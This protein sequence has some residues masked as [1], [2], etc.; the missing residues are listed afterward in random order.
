M[1]LSRTM[2]CLV[3]CV[4]ICILMMTAAQTNSLTA[5][6]DSE[7]NRS[8]PQTQ[9]AAE[10]CSSGKIVTVILHGL[11][12]GRMRKKDKF[13]VGIVKRAPY[14]K[15]NLTVYTPGD[16]THPASCTPIDREL[17]SKNMVFELRTDPGNRDIDKNIKPYHS[18]A[19]E[20]P[21]WA[22]DYN[23]ILNIEEREGIK[24][25]IDVRFKQTFKPIFR[26]HH[27]LVKADLLT[28]ALKAKQVEAEPLPDFWTCIGSIAEV[29]KVEICV[30]PGQALVLRHNGD[31]NN[32]VKKLTYDQIRPGTEIRLVNLPPYHTD[33]R[34][35][36]CKPYKDCLC[37]CVEPMPEKEFL[38][39]QK[40]PAIASLPGDDQLEPTHFQYYYYLAFDIDRP[41]RYEL[42]TSQDV[43]GC[44]REVKRGEVVITTVPPYR[45]GMVL[46]NGSIE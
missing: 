11:M 24:Q 15:L 13:E 32:P 44:C 40:G 46:I 4:L 16:Q 30:S 23:R 20:G 17:L 12:V 34:A 35:D 6:G 1:K 25:P 39:A 5:E 7:V 27:G 42:K 9:P 28:V 10:D 38:Q 33:E 43:V 18:S 26:F 45:C 14:H 29:A 3:A 21:E 41:K 37:P 8:E 22:A 31:I 2:P 36:C 19:L